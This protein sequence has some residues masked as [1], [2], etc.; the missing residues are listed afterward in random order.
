MQGAIRN[1]QNRYVFELD[2]HKKKKNAHVHRSK[3]ASQNHACKG[4]IVAIVRLSRD[5]SMIVWIC[6]GLRSCK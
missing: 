1:V 5:L 4:K 3:S 2:Y 6:V